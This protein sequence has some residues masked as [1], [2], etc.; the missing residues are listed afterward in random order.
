[1]SGGNLSQEL[2]YSSLFTGIYFADMVSKSS[3]YCF[4]SAANP[5]G[6]M[7]LS[8]VALG[9]TMDLTKAQFIKRLSSDY[10]SVRGLGKTYPD[11]SMA[12]KTSDG[13]VMPLG[14]PVTSDKIKSE[15]LYNEYIVYD[16]AQV[17]IK[18]L[19]KMKFAFKKK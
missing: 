16:V 3:N 8:E 5:A 19:L 4:A 15:L 12:H 11:P 14:K 10:H 13:V 7:V 6:L 9:D 17:N 18:Y 1:M 2:S